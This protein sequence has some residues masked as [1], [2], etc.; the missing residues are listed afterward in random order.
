M[1]D[2]PR[3]FVVHQ[4]TKIDE[5]TGAVIGD[6]DL[7]PALLFGELVEVVPP[8]WGLENVRDTFSMIEER[9]STITE[10][11]FLLLTGYPEF[12]AFAGAVAARN[13]NGRM[14]LLKWIKRSHSYIPMVINLRPE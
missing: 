9:L 2:N 8:G 6:K 1:S 13:L 10:A 4:S 12:I 11:D 14:K 3:V 7:S 5:S